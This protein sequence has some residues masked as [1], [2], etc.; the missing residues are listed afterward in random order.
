MLAD[1]LPIISV[2]F[3]GC[4]VAILYLGYRLYREV[5]RKDNEREIIEIKS[6]NLKF[7]L[8]ISLIFLVMGPGFQILENV[9]SNSQKNSLHLVIY[10]K[11]EEMP[12]NTPMPDIRLKAEPLALK[13][14]GYVADIKNNDTLS[15]T[16]YGII[17]SIKDLKKEIT[18][19]NVENHKKAYF[20]N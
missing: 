11:K 20:E 2:G 3:H 6:K 15:I 12:E 19:L 13:D 1:L 18:R 17:D 7:F 5:V 16:I 8:V 9:L 4:A 10:P 14:G